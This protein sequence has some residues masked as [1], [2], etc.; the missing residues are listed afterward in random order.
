MSEGVSRVLS[1]HVA[2]TRSADLPRHAMEQARLSLIDALGVTLGASGL[3]EGCDAFAEIARETAPGGH[4]VVPGYGFATSA[5]MAA[6][7]NGAMAHALDFEDTHDH[8]I[9]H[10]HAA[11]IA[12]AL[13]LCGDPARPVSGTELLGAI[14][15][16]GDL[17]CRLAAS[18][19]VNPDGFGWH[20]TPWLGVFGAATAAGQLLG[21]DADGM[22]A[23]W[24]LALSQMSS[25]GALRHSP[26]SHIRAVRDG[27]AA[28]AGVLGAM[29]A[30]R[31]VLG[32]AEPLEGKAGF[33]DAV[34]R[35]EVDTAPILDGLGTVWRGAE[36]SFKP[37][38]CCRGTH[39]YVEAGL[40]IRA[41]PGYSLLALGVIEAVV[42][43]KNRMLC[44]PTAHKRRPDTAIGAK[45]SIPFTLAT[46]LVKGRVDL[47]SFFPEALA[48]AEVLAV[49]ERITCRIDP[50]IPLR[51]TVSGTVRLSLDGTGHEV[52]VSPAP[53]HPDLPMTPAQMRGKFEDCAS[54]AR[55]A[56]PPGRRAALWAQLQD[57]ASLPTMGPVMDLMRAD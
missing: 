4:A 44:E 27:F 38:P 50:T 17:V 29:L 32:F 41:L 45:F 8:A 9:A 42:S 46:A 10:P 56:L 47:A 11:A 48:D 1:T 33:F 49:A 57:V 26:G 43:E 20:T 35:R 12:A 23:A 3:G 55:T 21:L 7:V 16:S 30:A 15:V 24:S 53:G 52:R 34:A 19:R 31:G 51:D 14:A 6:W 54:H 2:T 18:F 22:R 25:F 39:S 40:R 37:W 5:P 36:V 28:K 13:A